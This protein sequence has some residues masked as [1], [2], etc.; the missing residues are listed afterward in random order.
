MNLNLPQDPGEKSLWAD[1]ATG[2]P[3]SETLRESLQA[4]VLV[5]GAGHTGLSTALHLAEQGVSVVILEA[6]DVGYGGS[7]RSAG[8]VNAGVWKT[9]EFVVNQLGQ[10]AGDRFNQALYNSP[11]VV[12]D[13]V[14]R[15]NIECDADQTGT[16]NI[17]HKAS[18]ME[19]LEDRCEQLIKIGASTRMLD[20][21]EARSIS[22]S[23]VYR[24]GGIFDPNAGTIQPLSFVRGLASAA[25]EKGVKIYQQSPLLKLTRDGNRWLAATDAGQVVADQVVMATNAYAD[26]NCEG[27]R[28]SS[29]PVYIFQC[30]TG[31]LPDSIAESIIPQRHGLWDTQ[32]LMTSS[33][34]DAAGRLVMSCAGSLRGAFKSVRQDWMTRTRNRLYPQAKGIPWTYHWT[35]R[36]G[37]TSTRLLRIQLLAPGVFAPAG[38][39]GRGIGA[40]TAIG[41]YLAETLVSGNRHEF[42]FP[43]QKV[44]RE[45]W[46]GLRSAY[47]EYATLALQ[48]FDRR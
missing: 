46:R 35:G 4:D 19:Y 13:L 39:N 20:G 22:G 32:S 15:Y 37:L 29:V 21:S 33:R 8:L 7:G 3:V 28:E 40:G 26:K 12:F 11:S 31:S 23:P 44:Y 10:E 41:K 6:C 43:I 18:A 1:S 16:V 42:P 27:V 38:F 34:I 47:Y 24:H 5:V 2:N 36:V 48:N 25:I 30:A 9:P 17:A 45:S 14:Q